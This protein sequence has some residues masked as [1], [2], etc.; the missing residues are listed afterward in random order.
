MGEGPRLTGV[1]L[2]AGMSKTLHHGLVI[3]E[4]LARRPEG[5]TV[6][7]VADAV[8][9]HRTVAHRLL[10]TLE[11]HQLVRRDE[12]KRVRLSTGL[13]SLAESVEHGLRAVAL[14]VLERLAETTQATA[15]LVVRESA[16]HARVLL[17]VE[18][19]RAPMHIAFKPGQ[20][21]EMPRG[22]AAMAILST[23]PPSEGERLEVARAR[24]D[25]YAISA[26]EVVPSTVGVSVG[27]PRGRTTPPAAIGLSLFDEASAHRTAPDVVAAA[28]ELQAL[29]P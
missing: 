28:K 16:T 21:I 10:R 25:G 18:P 22:S 4:E 1:E 5:L 29:L 2:D 26:G 12:H 17:V 11:A 19:R 13:V 7:E 15:H 6:T 3:L 8:G 27:V 24:A 9:V 14:P 20:S 23:E